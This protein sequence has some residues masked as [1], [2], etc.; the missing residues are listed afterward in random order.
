MQSS[1]I[2]HA[3]LQAAAKESSVSHSVAGS[4][5]RGNSSPRTPP[6]DAPRPPS[7]PIQSLSA[8]NPQHAYRYKSSSHISSSDARQA[9]RNERQYD[10]TQS[11]GSSSQP[12]SNKIPKEAMMFTGSANGDVM[13]NQSFA[14]PSASRPSN[15]SG[16][17]SKKKLTSFKRTEQIK[18]L[19]I[20][21]GTKTTHHVS[22]GGH[23]HEPDPE[24]GS[25]SIL[26]GLG[27]KNITHTPT[28]KASKPSSNSTQR[29]FS[30]TFGKESHKPKSRK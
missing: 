17:S 18:L 10:S 23:K 24:K 13:S 27:K 15:P 7:L 19:G 22:N 6:P 4:N 29:S 20:P 5:S 8:H 16:S 28:G 1:P 26:L 9:Q 25:Q 30:N 3:R 12:A 11:G 21:V 2:R 14:Q